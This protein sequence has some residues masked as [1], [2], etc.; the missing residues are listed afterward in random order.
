MHEKTRGNR[1]ESPWTAWLRCRS[2]DRPQGQRWRVRGSGG[3]GWQCALGPRG[4]AARCVKVLGPGPPGSRERRRSTG[5]RPVRRTLAARGVGD[6]EQHPLDHWTQTGDVDFRGA[7]ALTLGR[8]CLLSENLVGWF[9]LR[10]L[11]RAVP[12]AA[13]SLGDAA[14]PGHDA[15]HHRVAALL[16]GPSRW[17]A[18][19]NSVE[20]ST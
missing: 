1:K 19:L 14:R 10:L 9:V 5:T 20:S 17:S 16:S 6:R 4:P 3:G 8:G 18:R 11:C 7:F 2:E 12:R 13:A 15:L